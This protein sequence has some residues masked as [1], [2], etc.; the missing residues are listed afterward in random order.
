VYEE[1]AP[2]L[3]QHREIIFALLRLAWAFAYAYLTG[4]EQIHLTARRKILPRESLIPAMR[5]TETR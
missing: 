1:E 2:G 5:V 4:A 3:L